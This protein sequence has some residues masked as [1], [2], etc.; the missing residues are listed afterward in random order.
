MPRRMNRLLQLLVFLAGLAVI[1]WVGVGYAGANALASTVTL[2]IAALYLVGAIELRRFAGDTQVLN[3]AVSALDHPP[4]AL[5]PW[6]EGLPAGLRSAVRRRVEGLSSPLPGPSLAPYLAG[7]L[8]LMGMLGTFLG[9]VLTLKGTGSA[10]ALSSDLATVRDALV[11]PVKG[12]GLAFG[13]SIAGVA[14]SAALGLLSAL[15]RRD[16]VGTVQALDACIATRLQGFSAAAQ[17]EESL[18]LLQ[19]QTALMP[20]LVEQLQTLVTSLDRRTQETQERLVAGQS[21]FHERTEAAFTGLATSVERSLQQ[22]LSRALEESAK[23]TSA[24]LAP[25]VDS[26]LHGIAR[27]TQSL[28][29]QLAGAV[30][31]QLAQLGQ[32]F[33]ASVARV[34]EGWQQA[35]S[36]QARQGQTQT[37]AMGQALERFSSA[38]EAR[39]SALVGS[40]AQQQQEQQTAQTRQTEALLA[41]TREAQQSAAERFEQQAAALLQN[42]T[43]TRAELQAESAQRDAAHLAEMR[44]GLEA[45]AGRLQSTW[46]RAGAD[47]LNQQQR[48]GAALEGAAQRFEQH[49]ATLVQG[50]TQAQE[51]ARAAANERDEARLLAITASLAEVST[52]LQ[53]HWTEAG[54]Q[55]LSQQQQICQT[56]ERTARDISAQAETHAR[57]TVTEVARLVDTAAQAPRAAAEVIAELREQISASMARDNAQL[58]ER[59]QL[60]ETLHTLLAAVTQAANEQR[61]A[62]D[63]LVD[64]SSRTLASAVERF[65]Q[66]L[67]AQSQPLGEVAA[68]LTAGSVEVGSLAEAFGQSVQLFTQSSQQLGGQLDRIEGALSQTLARSDEQL[69]YY[70]AQAREVIDL[71]I[72]SQKQI[73]DDLQRMASRPVQ[74]SE[75]AEGAAA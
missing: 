65:D 40:L 52:Q 21:Q 17:R 16:R 6:L 54:A 49:A 47:S 35:L 12:L 1:A 20:A 13:T 4:E 19:Q 62:I 10:L 9:M 50:I 3:Q 60:L 64:A 38:F 8:V 37:A 58:D 14:G 23:A 66:T 63:A 11:A 29:Q 68:Q 51:E 30:Q 67:A 36:E 59:A 2:L 72:L 74:P 7:L 5:A 57:S 43:Q 55:H 46:E 48:V 44:Q 56:L 45:M 70:V 61:G 69:A 18:R 25:A 39:A 71:S 34:N 41:Q 31:Q 26:T 32:G 53:R 75:P 24:T 28:Q 27:E 15:V 42:I 33:E 73:L 22:S